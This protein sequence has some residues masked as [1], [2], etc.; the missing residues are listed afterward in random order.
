MCPVHV[1][2]M[3]NHFSQAWL[4]HQWDYN[5]ICAGNA[6]TVLLSQMLYFYIFFP[7]SQRTLRSKMFK[8]KDLGVLIYSDLSMSR[9]CM[10]AASEADRVLKMVKRQF[11][12]LDKESFLIIY[13]DLMGL[14]WIY[15]SLVILLAERY[16]L[17][18]KYSKRTTKIA[19]GFCKR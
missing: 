17:S 11:K 18:E 7:F 3:S 16:W 15:S 1:F 19:K 2:G 14:I 9:K 10:E 8:R 6:G 12:E 13:K 5:C 4:S